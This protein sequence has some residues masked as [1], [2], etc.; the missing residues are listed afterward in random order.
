MASSAQI[1]VPTGATATKLIDSAGY[2]P[3][4]SLLLFNTGTVTVLL[5]GSG[6]TTSNGF[7]GLD[8][9]ATLG[10][11]ASESVYGVVSGATAGSVDVLRVS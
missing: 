4:D 11:N 10:I 1:A 9:G 7:R 2:S 5:G 8:A 6:V 3:G